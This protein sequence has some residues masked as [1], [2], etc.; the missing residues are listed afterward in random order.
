MHVAD[1]DQPALARCRRLIAAALRS[2]RLP[3]VD[4]VGS[5]KVPEPPSNSTER[6]PHSRRRRIVLA[7]AGVFGVLLVLL[8]AWDRDAVVMWRQETG[9]LPFF[10]AMAI[11]PAVGVPLTPFLILAGAVFGTRSALIGTAIAVGLNLT[12]CYFAARSLRPLLGNLLRRFSYDLP[13]F[14]ERGSSAVRFTLAVKA[15]PGVPTFIKNYG[16]ALAGVPFPLYFGLSM[17]MTA[18]YAVLLIFIGESLL[19]HRPD[20]ALIVAG[21]LAIGGA[22]WWLRRRRIARSAA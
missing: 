10:S 16:L 15:A 1:T 21:L 13:D 4:G 5:W 7:A 14:K 12:L 11:L 17:A 20:Q 6:V 19:E 22:A 2:Q 3:P 8:I 9:P 18:I